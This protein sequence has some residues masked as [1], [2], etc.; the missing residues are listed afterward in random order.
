MCC[1]LWQTRAVS[2]A[3]VSSPLNHLPVPARAFL[4]VRNHSTPS[5]FQMPHRLSGPDGCALSHR[6][7]PTPDGSRGERPSARAQFQ[8][9][10]PSN[11]ATQYDSKCTL[12]TL[13]Q[14][15]NT[16]AAVS[17]RATLNC[18]AFVEAHR[19]ES[20]YD[21]AS[22]VGLAVN[23]KATL[24]LSARSLAY[25]IGIHS[26]YVTGFPTEWH[27][28]MCLRTVATTGGELLLRSVLNWPR[29]V[30]VS[31]RKTPCYSPRA[32][33]C[34]PVCSQS[35]RFAD[36]ALA[37]RV[38]LPN[39]AGITYAA[40]LLALSVSATFLTFDSPNLFVC[41]QCASHLPRGYSNTFPRKCNASTGATST[42]SP[43]LSTQ[44]AR[45][46][47]ATTRTQTQLELTRTMWELSTTHY[48]DSWGFSSYSTRTQ[49]SSLDASHHRLWLTPRWQIP[50]RTL[51]FVSRE[52]V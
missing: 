2:S 27:A 46:P 34:Y 35:S 36:R 29:Q 17:L 3:Q 18:E 7:R 13:L 43:S 16:V 31:D 50:P 19:S 26:E 25:T 30:S 47:R 48:W 12:T 42:M 38:L 49:T 6:A 8:C 10:L 24:E 52:L 28:C 39:A 4:F 45:R 41:S 37:Q 21:R 33:P 5:N 14:V 44:A 9:A 40:C 32:D 11:E 20:H 15:I 22:F 51:A 23:L 1:R